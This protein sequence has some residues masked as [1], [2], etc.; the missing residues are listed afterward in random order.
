MV[1]AK[2]NKKKGQAVG[3][4]GAGAGSDSD[5]MSMARRASAS[6]KHLQWFGKSRSASF[7][8]EGDEV[9]DDGAIEMKSKPIINLG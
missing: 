8:G 3:G 1:K 6:I 7:E 9:I 5:G 4:A 2:M